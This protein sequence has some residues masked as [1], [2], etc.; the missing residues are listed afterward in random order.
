M[1][2]VSICLIMVFC[3]FKYVLMEIY[4]DGKG[5]ELGNCYLNVSWFCIMLE[6]FRKFKVN[7]LFLNK[8]WV[9]EN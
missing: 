7:Y 6:F 4:V 1:L 5:W 8:I 2:R 3:L 9:G